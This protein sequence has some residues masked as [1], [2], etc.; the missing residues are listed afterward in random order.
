MTAWIIWHFH[1]ITKFFQKC[2]PL[3]MF[4]PLQG[5]MKHVPHLSGN[6]I[7]LLTETLPC[8][9]AQQTNWTIFNTV[10]RF[11]HCHLPATR[12][13]KI[14]SNSLNLSFLSYKISIVIS[15][16]PICCAMRKSIQMV[17]TRPSSSPSAEMLPDSPEEV[18]P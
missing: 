10:L 4:M 11:P 1:E 16:F 18:F 3:F 2:I 15:V 12:P 8:G 9:K 5:C 17:V 7:L 6:L 13:W 14:C